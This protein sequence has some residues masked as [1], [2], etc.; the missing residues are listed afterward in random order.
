MS[1]EYLWIVTLCFAVVIMVVSQIMD[2][3]ARRATSLGYIDIEDCVYVFVIYFIILTAVSYAVG[4]IGIH[5]TIETC[6]TQTI[7]IYKMNDSTFEVVQGKSSMNYVVYTQ[8]EDGSIVGKNL[9]FKATKIVIDSE[10]GEED[11]FEIISEKHTSPIGIYI[12]S[13][14]YVIHT[15]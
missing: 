8:D 4:Y 5:H 15:H 7:P 11:Y 6:D 10:D 9:L 13:D 2:L 1:Y 14:R 12:M 3:K